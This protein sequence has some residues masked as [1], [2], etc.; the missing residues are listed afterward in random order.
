MPE[1]AALA[2]PPVTASP[3]PRSRRTTYPYIGGELI[4]V[5]MVSIASFGLLALLIAVDRLR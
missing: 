4:R 5:L 2:A 3:V 1:R